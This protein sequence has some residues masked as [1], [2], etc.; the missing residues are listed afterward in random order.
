MFTLL[1]KS[2]FVFL[3]FF[4]LF[5]AI[6]LFHLNG[7]SQSLYSEGMGSYLF[8]VNK[9]DSSK[10][11]WAKPNLT[12]KYSW[13]PKDEH[14]YWIKGELWLA[15]IPNYNLHTGFK[16][17][18]DTKEKP[19]ARNKR[20]IFY[21]SQFIAYEN[22]PIQEHHIAKRNGVL[23]YNE[24]E[25]FP[26]NNSELAKS[27]YWYPINND[28][29]INSIQK[30]ML[31]MDKLIHHQS[32]LSRNSRESIYAKQEYEKLAQSF[33]VQLNYACRELVTT[34]QNSFGL[35]Y[36]Q[37]G[38][39]SY[40]IAATDSAYVK[41]GD[42]VCN[43]WHMP[44]GMALGPNSGIHLDEI[45][46]ES[47]I[48]IVLNGPL[49]EPA[50]TVLYP[51]SKGVPK[52]EGAPNGRFPDALATSKVKETTPKESFDLNNNAADSNSASQN[53]NDGFIEVKRTSSTF[54]RASK[55]I[56]ELDYSQGKKFKNRG[57]G[58][59]EQKLPDG[60]D[61]WEFRFPHEKQTEAGAKRIVI[62][63]NTGNWWITKNHYKT[64]GPM[65]KGSI[66]INTLE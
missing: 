12:E 58:I 49:P 65:Q 48:S 9:N 11:Q 62:D 20:E 36:D 31:I 54:N 47:A 60:G 63:K 57:D 53:E 61:Y 39:A 46:K 7:I 32:V 30:Y 24:D 4:I 38:V 51:T 35:E 6:C 23:N 17:H 21:L 14:G 16:I 42:Q 41:A 3:K 13:A 59:K 37:I 66:A 52:I 26:I 33:G 45:L 56:A 25:A 44:K 50:E 5:Y 27:N 29:E 64:F 28:E 8:C 22:T 43:N 2:F 10:W 19:L 34:C 18:F 55:K 15:N 1:L 40:S